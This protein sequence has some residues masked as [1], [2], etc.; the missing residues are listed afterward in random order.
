MM[1]RNC[2]FD[3]KKSKI[4]LWEQ[5]N[6]ENLYTT[7][8]WVPY[9]FI[10]SNSGD[11]TTISGDPVVKKT[12]N[13]YYEY[14]EFN[15]RNGQIIFEN[16]VRPEI[17][18]LVD[19]YYNIQDTDIIPP[20]LKSIYLDIEVFI[21]DPSNINGWKPENADCP[22]VLISCY[23]DSKN[24][25]TVFGLKPY[26]GKYSKEN[27]INY[28]QCSDEGNLLITF[29]NYI[30]KTQPDVISGWNISQYDIPYIINRVINLFGDKSN[31]YDKLSPIGIVRFWS[32]E[33]IYNID[34]AGVSILDYMEIYKWYSPHKL[35]SYSLDFVAKYEIDK[36]KLDYSQ[37]NDLQQLSV[38]NWDMFVTYNIIDAL[39]VYQL[40]DKLGYIKQ[41]QTLSLLT[42]VPMKFYQTLT[43]L[44]EGLL[45]K[46]LRRRKMCAPHL[47]GGSQEGYEGAFVKEPLRGLYDWVCDLDI[48]SSYPTAIITLNMSIET[49]IGKIVNISESEMIEYTMKQSFPPFTMMVGYEA[50]KFEDDKLKKFNK[51]LKNRLI[52]IS[53]SGA[54]FRTKPPGVIASVERELFWR[55]VE[56]KDNMKNLK[57]KLPSLRGDNFNKTQEKV[58][59]LNNL[60]NA[61]K[62]MLNSMYGATAVPYSRWYNKNISEAVTSCARNTIKMGVNYVN[63]IL[64]N[65]NDKL[66][67]TLEEIRKE[68]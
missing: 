48:V 65:P 7:I 66:L 27:F 36:G 12:F 33:G 39:R 64:N 52:C 34:I 23:D 28:I 41:I 4:Y 51:A 26:N 3:T 22:I 43:T 56:T 2:F 54:C 44:L 47:Y 38:E 8:D 32:R 18:F 19:R 35:M 15:D 62:T 29:L 59:R 24:K 14:Y 50:I 49:Y 46:Y 16:K 58:Y 9:V 31:L 68:L 42:C 30:H 40:E 37:Y 57:S 11:I 55:R 1:F 61:Y 10:R 6:G 21:D 5:I 45:L 20:K 25:T 60:Q 63:E 17:Q 13:S 53:P 67:K